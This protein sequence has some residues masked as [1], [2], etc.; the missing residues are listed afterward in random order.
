MLEQHCPLSYVSHRDDGGDEEGQTNK[1]TNKT[2]ASDGQ[3]FRKCENF[4]FRLL[5][6]LYFLL[7][8]FIMLPCLDNF[9]LCFCFSTN[10]VLLL[11]WGAE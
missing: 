1:Q 5:S 6:F 11:S 3:A 9:F 2:R 10:I 4:T 8:E 7:A